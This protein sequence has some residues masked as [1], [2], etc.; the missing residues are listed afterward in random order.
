[1]VFNFQLLPVTGGQ[2]GTLTN[3]DTRNPILYIDFPEGRLRISGTMIFPNNRYI[4]LRP[5]S[6]EIL[7][8]DV[9]DNLIVFSKHEWIGRAE[10]NPRD[11]A[12]PMP[13]SLKERIIH[14]DIEFGT[15]HTNAVGDDNLNSAGKDSD[16]EDVAPINNKNKQRPCRASV[17]KRRRY[18]EDSDASLIDSL[19]EGS[20][21]GGDV[22]PALGDRDSD[23]RNNSKLLRRR[24]S[25]IVASQSQNE[26]QR[27]SD[28]AKNFEDNVIVLMS[29][30]Q[31]DCSEDG[32]DHSLQLAT[33]AANQST[34]Q[35]PCTRQ[36][37]TSR[38][39]SKIDDP[40]ESEEV[41]YDSSSSEEYEND[42]DWDG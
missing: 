19:S 7:C 33:T 20:E 24:Q 14:G 30:T 21:D 23:G 38:H 31:E 12:L 35:Q 6:K 27:E 41:Y 11:L 4:M 22:H 36:R 17:A 10:D 15:I 29:E 5:G 1:M 39:M 18:A 32:G 40:S 8:E 37:H 13:N 2:L 28:H 25:I 3:M 34:G 26:S 9:L 16:I 42:D